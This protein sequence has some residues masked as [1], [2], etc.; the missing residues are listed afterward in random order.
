MLNYIY[1][2]RSSSHKHMH[3]GQRYGPSFETNATNVV[4]QVGSTATIDCKINLL[5]DNA[6]SRVRGVPPWPAW[7]PYPSGTL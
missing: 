7:S 1:D 3:H 6:V 2:A 4:V 5:Q